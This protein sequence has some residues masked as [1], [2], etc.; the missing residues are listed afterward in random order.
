VFVVYRPESFMSKILICKGIRMYIYFLKLPVF[1]Q[2]AERA[3]GVFDDCFVPCFQFW[4]A[5]PYKSV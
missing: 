5:V 2:W 3:E 1:Y 4:F